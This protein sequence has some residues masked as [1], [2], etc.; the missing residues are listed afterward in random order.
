[1][2]IIV[3]T[4][5]FQNLCIILLAIQKIVEDAE[6]EWIEQL[7]TKDE[8]INSSRSQYNQ[9]SRQLIEAQRTMQWCRSQEKEC[10]ET[11]TR[12]KFLE[13]VLRGERDENQ[14]DFV[15]RKRQKLTHSNGNDSND[16][17]S[18]QN[19]ASLS[20]ISSSVTPK[21]TTDSTALTK[22]TTADGSF[23]DVASTST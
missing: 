3:K 21:E 17:S 7:K 9:N 6:N 22:S 19:S 8:Q 10:D 13:V 18:I 12:I 1:M 23:N 5:H 20:A 11:E 2:N 14:E 16:I 15:L 4:R